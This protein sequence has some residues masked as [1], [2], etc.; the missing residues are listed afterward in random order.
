MLKTTLCLILQILTL[1]HINCAY[2]SDSKYEIDNTNEQ[3]TIETSKYFKKIKLKSYIKTLV[4]RK[5]RKDINFLK[6]NYNNS[7]VI[8]NSY[9]LVNLRNRNNKI[10]LNYSIK[11]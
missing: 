11:F 3:L 1:C 6:L 7:K 5:Y 8:E 4:Q 2:S 10:S 9:L